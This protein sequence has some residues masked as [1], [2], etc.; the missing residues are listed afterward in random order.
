MMNREEKIAAKKQAAIICHKK[1]QYYTYDHKM[2]GEERWCIMCGQP[3]SW[4]VAE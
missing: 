2:Q 4:H 3:E 1:R